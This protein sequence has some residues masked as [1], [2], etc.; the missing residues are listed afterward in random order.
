MRYDGIRDLTEFG[1]HT[2]R[3]VKTYGSS[4]QEEKRQNIIVVQHT[5]FVKFKVS[6]EK[7]CSYFNSVLIGLK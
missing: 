7:S 1:H 5:Q 6:K 2:L 4:K 3:S